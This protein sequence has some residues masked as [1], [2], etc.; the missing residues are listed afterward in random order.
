[1]RRQKSLIADRV[2]EARLKRRWTQADLADTLGLHPSAVSHFENSRA[3][4]L[5]NLVKLAKALEVTTDYLLG[6]N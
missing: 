5:R 3:P 1:M 2:R 6:M 4:K